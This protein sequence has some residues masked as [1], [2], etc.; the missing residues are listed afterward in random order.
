[1]TFTMRR[2][3]DLFVLF[4]PVTFHQIGN[5]LF[6][7]F[8][9]LLLLSHF[10]TRKNRRHGQNEYSKQKNQ[11]SASVHIITSCNNLSEML[12]QYCPVIS[13]TSKNA[14]K[15][16]WASTKTF[17]WVMTWGSLAAKANPSGVRSRHCCTVL[18]VGI[19]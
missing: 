7:R 11:Q 5:I 3:I 12:S 8:H 18:A 16:L 19:R 15:S 6:E 1:M 2:G 17:S 10:I 14:F 13:M 9:G 4:Y